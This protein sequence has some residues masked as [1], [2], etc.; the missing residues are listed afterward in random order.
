M[1]GTPRHD[2]HREDL[3]NYFYRGIL[4]F[5]FSAKA[6]GLD[7]LFKSISTFA[8]TFAQKAGRDYGVGRE[9]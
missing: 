3:W 6:F 4:A 7:E 9:A 1:R 2:E 5:S 8:D